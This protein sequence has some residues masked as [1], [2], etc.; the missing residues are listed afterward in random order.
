MSLAASPNQA[1]QPPTQ[2]E[3]KV[4]FLEVHDSSAKLLHLCRIAERHFTAKEPLQILVPDKAALEFVDALLWRL[5][6]ESFL[7]HATS[8]IPTQELV[9]ITTERAILNSALALFNLATSA[10]LDHPVKTVYDF[11]DHSSPE[12]KQASQHRYLAYRQ[13]GLPIANNL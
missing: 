2:M 9:V 5:P 6:E 1:K 7:P 13:A 11:D 10:F 4:I 8:E 12:K 3:N